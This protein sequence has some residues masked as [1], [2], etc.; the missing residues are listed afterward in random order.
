MQPRK[1]E[2]IPNIRIVLSKSFLVDLDTWKF[3]L[4]MKYYIYK[5]LT[6]NL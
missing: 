2:T 4:M 1:I 5:I 6:Y 3:V